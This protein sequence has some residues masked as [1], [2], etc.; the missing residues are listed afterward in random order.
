M[1]GEIHNE[2]TVEEC[3]VGRVQTLTSVQRV[4]INVMIVLEVS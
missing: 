2:M 1:E 3:F 4:C